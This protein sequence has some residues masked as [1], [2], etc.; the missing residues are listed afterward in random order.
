MGLG[1]MNSKVNNFLMQTSSVEN[2]KS[3]RDKA[4]PHLSPNSSQKSGIFPIGKQ[5]VDDSEV[6]SQKNDSPFFNGQEK[7]A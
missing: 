3:R 5:K 7:V 1:L 6:N 2:P 4:S